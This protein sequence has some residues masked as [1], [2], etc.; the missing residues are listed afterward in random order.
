LLNGH[1]FVIAALMLLL[2]KLVIWAISLGSGTSGGVLA[3][4]LIMGAGLGVMESTFLPGANPLI[5][6][7]VSMGAIIAGTMRSP[8]TAIVFTVELTQDISA[9]KPLLIACIVAHA[10]SVIVMKRSILT[11]KVARRGLHVFREY[12]VDPLGTLFVRDIMSQKVASISAELTADEAHSQYF[13]PVKQKYRA[14]PV[15]DRAGS[16]LA[17]VNRDDIARYCAEGPARSLADCLKDAKPEVATPD[18]TGREAAARMTLR[19]L[20]RLPVVSDDGQQRLLGMVTRF[21]LV[22]ALLEHYESDVVAE[23]LLNI[24]GQGAARTE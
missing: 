9:L 7:L 17:V 2:V 21:D 3:P 18:E 11:E 1:Y 5:W 23:K 16:L 6:P 22:N 19:Q 24:P 4:L 10:F 8:L 20:E 15:V 13:D 14:Y 12:S